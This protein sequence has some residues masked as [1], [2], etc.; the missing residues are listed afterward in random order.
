MD[1]VESKTDEKQSIPKAFQPAEV[2]CPSP[3]EEK[4]RVL[5]SPARY[6]QGAKITKHLGK[7]LKVLPSKSAGILVSKGGKERFGKILEES[8]TSNQIELVWLIFE[9]ECSYEV[10][11]KHKRLFLAWLLRMCEFKKKK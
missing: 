4:P 5:M 10:T 2:W 6:V 11:I 8:L 9:G 1:K 7:Y 3:K